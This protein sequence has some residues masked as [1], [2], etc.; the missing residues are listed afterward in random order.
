MRNTKASK[1]SDRHLGLIEEAQVEILNALGHADIND[2]ISSVV[3]EEILDA[4]P[5]DELLPKALNEIEALEE[6]RSIAKKNQIKR[7][8]IGLGYYGTYTPAVIQR[9]VFE[10]PAWY[11]SYTPYQA[12]I[13]QG[14][15]EALF[16][17]QTLITELTGLPIANASLLDEGTAAAEAM[18]LSFAVNKQT[19]A[20]KFIVDDQVLP[21]TLAV[22]KTRAEPLELDIEV[23]NLTDLVINETV[24][25]LLIQL[26]GKS[27]QLGDP[28][29]LIAQAHEFNALVTVAIDP[30]AQVLIAPMGQL[31]VDIAIGSS[32][33]FGVPIGFGGPHAAFFAIKEEYKR[34]VPGRLVGQSIDSKGHSALRLALQ[35]REQHIR[36]DKATSNICTAQALLATIASF[37]AVYHG[38]HGLEEIAKNI[39]YLRSQL[40]LYLKEFGYTF[41][42]DCRF[43]TLEIHCLEAPEIHR[44]SILSGFNLRILP[45]GASIEKSKGFAVS[46]DELSTTKELYKLCKI[47]A[48]VK[49]KNFEPRENTNFNFKE[50]LTSLPLRTTPWLKQQVFNNY[51]TETELMRYIQKLA[52]R[53][54]SLVNGMIPLG[55]CTMK[56]NATAELLPITWKEFSS[57]HPFVPSD[58][59]KGYG[60]LS[61]QLEGWLCALTGFDGVSLQPN[62]GSQGEFAGLLV[63]RAWHKAINQADRNICLIPKSAHGTNPASAVMAGFKVVAVECDEYGNIDFE[64]LVLKVETYSS[65]LGALMITYPSTH[66]VFEPNIRQ[67]CDQVHLHGGQVYLDGANLNAQVGL[68][69]PGAFGADVCHLNLHKTFCIPHGGGGPGIGPIAVAKHLVAFLPSKNFH[70]SDNN[71]A[72]GAISASPLGSASILPIS[73]MYIRMMGADGLRQASSLAIL[74]ANYIANKL[75]PYFQV[76]FKAPN[77]KVAHE[78]ILDLR[79][80]KRITGIEVDDVAKRLMDYG[81]H[82]PTISWPVAGTLMIEPTESESFEEINRF[83]EAMISIRSEIDAIESGIT[84]LS[85]NPLRLAPHTMETVTAEIWDRP[86]TRQQAAFPLKDQFMNKF[87]PAVSRIDN[88]F[89]DRNLVCSCST[90]EELSET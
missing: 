30:L 9:H 53:D 78:C 45:L 85:N 87:W 41:A 73:W 27:G 59:A 14:R 66:G 54:F 24:F 31:G 90:L 20:R 38:P 3:P 57:I 70:A 77:G 28:S 76:L 29:S 81:F 75:D 71:A 42:P 44:L 26:P 67:I 82:A 88:A 11:T 49:D 23:V 62:A 10:N 48:D 36:R 12:E 86:Y 72:I 39:I 15:L 89:G 19:K 50:S 79:S 16:N 51:R 32:Q 17:F 18:S 65:E 43:D 74:S 58:Q 5:P 13:A 25:G 35:T 7:S 84:D 68:C 6:L 64:D 4:Q 69:R 22:L 46:F 63:I 60:Y 2:F 83:C 37:Y 8:L 52:S 47:F 33:R 80:I 55:S 40:E 1:F 34:L 61:E 56:L 21:Q